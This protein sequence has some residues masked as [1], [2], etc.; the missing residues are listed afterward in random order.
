V[1]IVLIAAKQLEFA[2]TRLAPAL[3]AAAERIALAEAMFRD[4]L[5]AALS[6]RE[7][8]QAAIITSDRRLLDLARGAGAWVIDEEFPRGLNVAVR[9]A[10]ESLTSRGADTICT[11]LSDIPLVTGDDIDSVFKMMPQE[12]R[13]A[14]LVPSQDFS[15]TNMIARRP[16]DIIPTQF[17][18]F[19]LVRHLDDCRKRGL[20]CRVVRLARPAIDLDLPN[21]LLEFARVPTM[22]HTFNHLARLGMVHG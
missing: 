3:P 12:E 20:A 8:D 19:S 2:K 11:L 10:S 14:V 9:M 1:R 4:V 16:P 5:A 6:S 22:T 21:D 17:G 15:G 13:A 7:A 18:R